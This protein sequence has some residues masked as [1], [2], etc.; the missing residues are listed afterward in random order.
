LSAEFKKSRALFLS[1]VF[2]TIIIA[3]FVVPA[4]ANNLIQQTVVEQNDRNYRAIQAVILAGQARTKIL[5]NENQQSQHNIT[6]Q[7]KNVTQHIDTRLDEIG[8]ATAQKQ[9]IKGIFDNQRALQQILEIL[10]KTR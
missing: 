2:S 5:I 10:N 1:L 6:E 4:V 7:I 8:N 3:V 9:G